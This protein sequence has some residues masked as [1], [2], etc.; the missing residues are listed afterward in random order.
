MFWLRGGVFSFI[1]S[2]AQAWSYE[3]TT[4]LCRCLSGHPARELRYCDYEYD[5]LI[6]RQEAPN[7]LLRLRLH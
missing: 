2:D 1:S 5:A 7:G 3:R 4:A 6:S